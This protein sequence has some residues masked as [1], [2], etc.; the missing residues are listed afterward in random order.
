MKI[1][2]ARPQAIYET[3]MRLNQEDALF[4]AMGEATAD[5]RVFILCDGLGGHEKGEVASQ[6]V[7]GSMG[8]YLKE[9]LKNG[10]RVSDDLLQS[11]L[12]AAYEALDAK[13]DG[14]IK[15][16]GTTLCLIALHA[17]GATAMHIGDSRIYH[18]RPSERRIIY[19]SMD[20]SVVYE[21]F[22]HGSMTLDEM[23]RSPLRNRLTRAMQPGMYPRM[24]A[25][26]VHIA[27]IRRG[28]CFYVCSDGMLENMSRD[29]LCGLLSADEPD[30]VKRRRL[31]E[32]TADNHDNH[33]AWLISITDVVHEEGDDALEDDE[34]TSEDNAVR[35]F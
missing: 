30:S 1:T 10:Q 11:A 21:L 12:E 2:T 9:R 15:K 20:H 31:I 14:S 6:T 22:S 29:E 25:A 33:S 27:D 32:A 18:I 3:G 35:L 5:D 16:M 26:I 7:A 34:Q 8:R 19:Q 17:G 28:D 24:K 4:P 13:D 23:R